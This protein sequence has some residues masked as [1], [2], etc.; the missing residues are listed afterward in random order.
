MMTQEEKARAYDEAFELAKSW[1]V[2]AQRDF[3]KS[4]ENLFPKLKESEDE[5]IRKELIRAFQSLNTIE[6]WNG[7]KRTDI[8]A[9]LE[10]IGTV[11]SVDSSGK[12]KRRSFGG[13]SFR[14]SAAVRAAGSFGRQCHSHCSGSRPHRIR[15]DNRKACS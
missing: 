9:W 1:Y 8:I 13:Q 10:K 2:D 4:L 12:M 3:K 7:I 15:G 6:V 5:R 11:F 14:R